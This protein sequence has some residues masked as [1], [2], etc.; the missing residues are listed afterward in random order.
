MPQNFWCVVRI[1]ATRG[2]LLTPFQLEAEEV[3]L[4]TQPAPEKT[5]DVLDFTTKKPGDHDGAAPAAASP[6]RTSILFTGIKPA[7]TQLIIWE[8]SE[9][10]LV[11]DVGACAQKMKASPKL[12]IVVLPKR[13]YTSVKH[14][15]FSSELIQMGITT[16]CLNRVIDVPLM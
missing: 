9:G 15:R 3:V 10:R 7:P 1:R 4:L 16:Q 14:L 6:S 8:N 11:T 12:M 5:K 13:Y 2:F